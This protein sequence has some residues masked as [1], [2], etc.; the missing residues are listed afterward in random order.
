MYDIGQFFGLTDGDALTLLE[1]L[2]AR[3]QAEMYKR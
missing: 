2:A 1:R 3:H